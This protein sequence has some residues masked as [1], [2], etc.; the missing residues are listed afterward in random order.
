MAINCANT[1][2]FLPYLLVE[3]HPLL[4]ADQRFR[5]FRVMNRN[6]VRAHFGQGQDIFWSNKLSPRRLAEWTEASLGRS[7][8][9]SY[10]HKTGAPLT[11]LAEIA[12]IIA[13]SDEKTIRSCVAFARGFRRRFSDR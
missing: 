12:G 4:S 7:L 13:G 11:S 8:L 10:A 9:R 3:D 5:I 2:Y 1:L 6:F